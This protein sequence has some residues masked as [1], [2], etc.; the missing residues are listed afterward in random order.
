MRY[1][2]VQTKMDVEMRRILRLAAKQSARRIEALESSGG[3]GAAMRQVQLQA[4]LNAIDA[5]QQKMWRSGVLSTILK[6]IPIVG[7]AAIRASASIDRA[8]RAAVG[9]RRANAYLEGI[10]ASADAAI[11]LLRT[12]RERDLSR[13]VYR[14]ADLASGRV[15]DMIKA[16]IVQGL[17][18]KELARSVRKFID[19]AT[20][21]GV[22]YAAM[23]LARTEINNSFHDEQQ[24]L[25]KG[26]EEVKA[27]IWNLSSR[28]PPN[29]KHLCDQY[30]E[31]KRFKPDEVPDK[32]HP[33][34]LCYMTYDLISPSDM[35]A[36]MRKKLGKAA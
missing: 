12:R 27:V 21:G 18:A 36:L 32:P 29:P 2:T 22:S 19:P 34:C 5:D 10:Q 17:S 8:L 20:P 35:V 16:G 11:E 30:A 15:Q 25:V 14:N 4:V 6:Y 23:R 7:K 28:H 26:R 9:E 13:R 1:L 3:V 31:K 24:E 33:H